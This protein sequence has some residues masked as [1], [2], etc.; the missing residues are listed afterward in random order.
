MDR[1]GGGENTGC[2]F[3]LGA[4]CE[5][6]LYKDGGGR[7]AAWFG[8]NK[9]KTDVVL[10]VQ[11]LDWQGSSW[12]L[13]LV[14]DADT[15]V[16]TLTLCSTTCFDHPHCCHM[17]LTEQTVGL[18]CEMWM[19]RWEAFSSCLWY[20]PILIGQSTVSLPMHSVC[21]NGHWTESALRRMCSLI[22]QFVLVMCRSWF[23]FSTLWN[24]HVQQLYNK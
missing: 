24:L 20:K 8:K 23:G 16:L 5:E 22:L 10:R 17:L 12:S 13:T 18:V 4:C 3:K 6:C 19:D 21:R 15:W 14:W 9:K 2:P 7:A 1:E 11:G